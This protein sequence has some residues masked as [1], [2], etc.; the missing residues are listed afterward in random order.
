MSFQRTYSVWSFLKQKRTGFQEQIGCQIEKK[1]HDKKV[2]YF[3]G[4]DCAM[5]KTLGMGEALLWKR[6]GLVLSH[7]SQYWGWLQMTMVGISRWAQGDGPGEIWIFLMS[8][9]CGGDL[10]VETR[11][12]GD[13]PAAQPTHVSCTHVLYIASCHQ[14]AITT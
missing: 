11:T 8:D 9:S 12:S 7:D 10:I 14:I 2:L 6:K 5:I 4:K 1:L 13:M 3:T